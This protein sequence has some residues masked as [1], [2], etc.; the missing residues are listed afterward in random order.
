MTDP[1]DA[2]FG[3]LRPVG[4]FY[5]RSE[6]SGSWGFSVP[7]SPAAFHYIE[8][9]SVL[10]EAG[11]ESAVL[12]DGDLAVLPH[13]ESTTF[14]SDS[15]QPVEPVD[16]LS[17]RRPPGPDGVL[18]NGDGPP[19][20]SMVCGGVT[21]EDAVEHPVLEA[22]PP[23]LVVRDAA[24]EAEPWLANTLRFLAC[25]SQN[26]RP[27]ASTVMA[28]LSSV[29]FLQAVRAAI[30]DERV[31]NVGWLGALR[32]PYVGPALTVIQRTPAAPWTVEALGREVGLG[33]S[34]F[35]ARFRDVVGESPMRHVTR[36]RVYRASQ[37]LQA[38]ES[39]SETAHRVGY[40][41]EAAFSR[42]FKRWTGRSPGSVRRAA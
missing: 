38:N 36:W 1:L 2:A 11:G 5:Y 6:L 39:L 4:A 19:T 23:L 9:G 15:E 34:A 13:G 35:A 12:E 21:F 41:S 20:T 29:V 28:H 26:G 10:L 40:E 31:A 22:L 24:N 42:A 14:R 7:P 27:G 17:R 8:K 3:S 18:R 30:A 25:E 37:L 32:D 16:G 33:R